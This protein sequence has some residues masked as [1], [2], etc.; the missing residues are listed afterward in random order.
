MEVMW[1]IKENLMK[2]TLTYPKSTNTIV[3]QKVTLFYP[4]MCMVQFIQVLLLILLAIK[5]HQLTKNNQG[6]TW[7]SKSNLEIFFNCCI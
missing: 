5:T 1:S 4:I 2:N 7:V 6:L 3:T